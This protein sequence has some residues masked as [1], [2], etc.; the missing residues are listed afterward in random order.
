[1]TRGILYAIIMCVMTE[2]YINA[3]SF[4]HVY[5]EPDKA[6]RQVIY[7]DPGP[8]SARLTLQPKDLS[9]SIANSYID[10]PDDDCLWVGPYGSSPYTTPMPYSHVYYMFNGYSSREYVRIKGT[11]TKGGGG[12]GNNPWFRVTIPDVDID[13]DGYEDSQAEEREMIEKVYCPTM[14]TLSQCKKI[15]IRNP[16]DSNKMR[17][18]T[19]L[20]NSSLNLMLMWSP[21]NNFHIKDANNNVYQSGATFSLSGPHIFPVELYVEPISTMPPSDILIALYG[22]PGT[23]GTRSS[24]TIKGTSLAKIE[25]DSVENA[26]YIYDIENKNYFY[27]TSVKASEYVVIRLKTVPSTAMLPANTITW[28]GGVEGANQLERKVS[29]ATLREQAW[30]VI[31]QYYSQQVVFEIYVFK[32]A[33][34]AQSAVIIKNT[35]QDANVFNLPGISPT[36]HGIAWYGGTYIDLTTQADIYYKDKKWLFVLNS[37]SYH[38]RWDVRSLLRSDVPSAIASPF[39]LGF[40][41]AANSTEQQKKTAA[42]AD[43]APDV[44]GRPT[45]AYYWVESFTK[46]HELYHVDDFHSNYYLVQLGL[47][48]AKFEAVGNAVDVTAGTLVPLVILPFKENQ[49]K[50]IIVPEVCADAIQDFEPEME[51]RAYGNG[52]DGYQDLVDSIIP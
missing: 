22:P 28:Q 33:P 41:M 48:E 23:D 6:E 49:F 15:I 8:T 1:M 13:W 3:E 25:L 20:L 34:D 51:A 35:I 32:A 39:P 44:T 2:G 9:W 11:L 40:T 12:S 36:A 46:D 37:L 29:K 24:D 27:A 50:T 7:T 43:L 19:T 42:K 14:S 17:D 16:L 10:A 31:A 47:A 18:D 45:R 4:Y 21:I 38:F 30:T 5:L 26:D 52:K